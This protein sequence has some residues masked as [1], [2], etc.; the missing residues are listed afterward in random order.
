MS[1][2]QV[3]PVASGTRQT[4]VQ[5]RLPFSVGISKDFFSAPQPHSKHVAVKA[6]ISKNFLKRFSFCVVK[7][8][9]YIGYQFADEI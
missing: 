8:C 6:R 9:K 1:E 3:S 4:G 5:S 7:L 2:K